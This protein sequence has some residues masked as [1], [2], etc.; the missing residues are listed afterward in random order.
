MG[1][2]KT[3]ISIMSLFLMFFAAAVY[4]NAPVF[5]FP[6]V[7]VWF[8][9]I[10]HVNH[11]ASMPEEEFVKIKDEFL[12]VSSGI[13]FPFLENRKGVR[14]AVAI[15]C[16]IF[17][18][19]LCWQGIIPLIEPYIASEIRYFLRDIAFYAPK[20]VIGICIVALGISMIFGKK[21]KLEDEF[22]E[23]T[24]KTKEE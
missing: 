23:Q 2:M 13:Q 16:I 9:G 10:F 14:K 7:I 8:Y 21:E 5:M 22:M 24:E 19:S 6:G 18:I 17:G 11:L 4:F 15:I 20:T 1:F 3:G 12:F